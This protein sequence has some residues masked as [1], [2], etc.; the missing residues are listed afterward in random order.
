MLVVQTFVSGYRLSGMRVFL[1]PWISLGFLNVRHPTGGD[2]RS[3][4]EPNLFSLE[5]EHYGGYSSNPELSKCS[6]HLPWL[7]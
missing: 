4:Q 7:V 5:A 3:G 2:G 1:L 6:S